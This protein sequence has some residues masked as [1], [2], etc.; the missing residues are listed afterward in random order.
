MHL[1]RRKET[2]RRT[3]RVIAAAITA[4][5]T[6]S[7][8]SALAFADQD[9]KAAPAKTVVENTATVKMEKGFSNKAFP[10]T[11]T[12]TPETTPLPTPISGTDNNLSWTF[13]WVTG[14]LEITGT[15]VMGPEDTHKG[16]NVDRPQ[17]ETDCGRENI[18]SVTIGEGI[19][20]VATK[21]F[22]D[23]PYLK[24]VSI[25]STVQIID[26]NA[27]LDC[28]SLSDV[29]IADGVK[30]IESN[31]F[32]NCSSLESIVLPSSVEQVY[33]GAFYNCALKR[34]QVLSDLINLCNN[35]FYSTS[36]SLS[37]EIDSS[38]V[39]IEGHPFISRRETQV[40][41]PNISYIDFYFTSDTLGFYPDFFVKS[42]SLNSVKDSFPIA[43]YPGYRG[44][45]KGTL[46]GNSSYYTLNDGTLSILGTGE[47]FDFSANNAPWY[48]NRASITK[49]VI[50]EG[51]T[52]I[53]AKTF[54]GCNKVQTV[55]CNPN[56]YSL[57]WSC[58]AQYEFMKNK[59]TDCV[60]DTDYL[61]AYKEK[62]SDVNVTF[63]TSAN[64]VSV[65]VVA[66]G[67]EVYLV[68]QL[69]LQ[70]EDHGNS[71]EGYEIYKDNNDTP[72]AYDTDSG[73]YAIKC[74]AKD[75]TALIHF[76]I[77]NTRLGPSEPM[78][79]LLDKDVSVAMYLQSIVDNS[80]L[81]AY[82]NIANAM[83]C[84]GAAAQVYFDVDTDNL[85]NAGYDDAGFGK[86]PT[87]YNLTTYDGIAL[88]GWLPLTN[89]SYA[90]ISLRFTSSLGLYM[91]FKVDK[92][93]N[94]EAAIDELKTCIDNGSEY[95]YGGTDEVVY[96]KASASVLSLTSAVISFTRG[97]ESYSISAKD[98]IAKVIAAE[99]TTP[100]MA[101]LQILCKSLYV[102]GNAA[103]S[104]NA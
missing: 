54:N 1:F 96:V 94:K 31:A 14:H 43:G 79:T 87:S 48:A 47:L 18:Y 97:E 73:R 61:D 55:E 2:S 69:P 36:D 39:S 95:T 75:M 22:I 15:G 4:A 85:A 32:E 100:E 23:Y 49:V 98:Y 78:Y 77:I 93:S 83:L 76:Q 41:M 52:S 68:L 16:Y 50:D 92:D 11:S 27:F 90:G 10:M 82:H 56:P 58:N 63:V 7:T 5:L 3:S 33:D 53:G 29:T 21:A 88:R 35:C 59:A 34:V 44:E 46:C 99:A 25:P 103:T 71:F 51:I 13:D 12:P 30:I 104:A 6:L 42:S 28:P 17:W 24:S 81:S 45:V 86:L 74:S 67:S 72:V 101:A 64:N 38:I 66:S 37:V 70:D 8:F 91:F 102:F 60:V 26:L 40:F 84:Y 89:S 80:G 19:T 20:H 62:F 9:T 65:G 57:E